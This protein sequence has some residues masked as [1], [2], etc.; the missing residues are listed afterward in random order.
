MNSRSP[1][2]VPQ[3]DHAF[4]EAVA[5]LS[6][7]RVLL[8]GDLM[9]DEQ[10][11]G[12]AERLSPDAPVPVLSVDPASE[13]IERAA[14]G[15]GNVAVCLRGLD[16]EC[17]VVGLVGADD[18]GEHIARALVAAGC[19]TAGL[20]EDASRPTTIK[21]SLIGLAQHRHPQKMFRLDIESK[22]SAPKEAVA[23]LLA[24][25][26]RGLDGADVVCIEDYD[27]GVCTPE[28]CQRVIGLCRERGVPVIVDPAS[29]D[30]FTKY[31]GATAITPNRSEAERA[32]KAP[33]LISR[34]IERACALAE[35]MREA[36]DLERV[37]LTLDAD[38]AVLVDDASWT[39]LSDRGAGRCTTSPVRATWCSLGLRRAWQTGLTG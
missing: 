35:A 39:H 37:V 5:R 13:S 38:G 31:R 18:A 17:D 36:H 12:A 4:L 20:V 26:K 23:A 24:A 6:G 21:R 2:H 27:K 34:D 19:G 32:M 29:I 9:L 25:F 1:E 30:D 28:L 15:A 7:G 11:R 10:L 33:G 3:A 22:R 14:G 16:V 8:V